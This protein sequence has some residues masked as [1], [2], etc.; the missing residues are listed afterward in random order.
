MNATIRQLLETADLLIEHDGGPVAAAPAPPSESTPT[1]ACR[2]R[3]AAFALRAALEGAVTLCLAAHGAPRAAREGGMRA[4]FLWLR[5]CADA[6]A[7]RRAKAAWSQLCVGCHYHLYEIGPAEDQIRA[8]RT[9]VAAVV[10][11]LAR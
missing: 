5:G 7:A 6:G 2:Y 4:A 10:V 3:G 9:D 8:W 11:L 1:A